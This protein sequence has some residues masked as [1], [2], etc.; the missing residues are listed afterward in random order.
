M[1]DEGSSDAAEDRVNSSDELTSSEPEDETDRSFGE[2]Y[3]ALLETPVPPNKCPILCFSKLPHKLH[4]LREEQNRKEREALHLSSTKRRLLNSCH[5]TIDEF[6]TAR[7]A[8]IRKQAT[9]GVIALFNSNAKAKAK[10]LIPEPVPEEEV[11]KK[12]EELLDL[13]MQA[14]MKPGK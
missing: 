3:L 14:A 5:K 10:P 6:D 9:R 4:K 1:S 12:Q 7:E 2:Q 11:P 13:I 8:Q